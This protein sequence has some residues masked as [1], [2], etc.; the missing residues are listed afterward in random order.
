MVLRKKA[1]ELEEVEFELTRAKLQ[2]L[3]AEL[4][5]IK[6]VKKMAKKLEEVQIEL[7][8]HK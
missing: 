5:V 7:A 3:E 6:E 2:Q 8:K 4:V 1:K